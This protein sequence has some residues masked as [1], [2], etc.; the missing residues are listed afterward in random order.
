MKTIMMAAMLLIG[1]ALGYLMAGDDVVSAEESHSLMPVQSGL[2]T[3]AKAAPSIMSTARCAA[4]SGVATV[5][6]AG[7]SRPTNVMSATDRT[8]HSHAA[9]GSM[10][11][12]IDL[13]S[14][15][16]QVQQQLPP[17]TALVLQVHQDDFRQMLQEHRQDS[18]TSDE[19]WQFQ[20]QLSDFF[21]QHPAVL[22][23]SNLHC[24]SRYCELELALID[25]ARWPALFASLSQQSWW[26]AVSY[27]SESEQS[28]HTNNLHLLLQL[29]AVAELHVSWQPDDGQF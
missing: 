21:S 2:H 4:D 23:L 29:P 22:T 26:Q 7:Q 19:S 18:H 24:S 28:H 5:A 12:S 8:G 6:S 20:Q 9:N 16:E 15:T 14:Y 27:Q 25:R 1:Y 11:L 13:A 3:P 17:A 10:E